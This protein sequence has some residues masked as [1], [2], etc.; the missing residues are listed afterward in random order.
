MGR[1]LIVAP[2]GQPAGWRNAKYVLDGMEKESCTSLTL[3]VEKF[4]VEN[5]D[6]AILALDSLVDEYDKQAESKCYTCYDGLRNV[7]RES[8][9]AKTYGELRQSSTSF[10]KKF[11][12]CLGLS[13]NPFVIICPAIGSPGGNWKFI[14]APSD[15]EALALYEIGRRCIETAYNRIVLDLSHGVNFMPA[16]TLKIA[17]GLISLILATHGEEAKELKNGVELQVY[18]SDPPPSTSS[19]SRLNINLITKS[20]VKTIIAPHQLSRR[21]LKHRGRDE[22]LMTEVEK[23]NSQYREAV[24]LSLSAVYYPLPLA[25]C[26]ASIQNNKDQQPK[27][28]LENAF[29]LWCQ[30]INVGNEVVERLLEIYPD[31]VYA[32][33]LTEAV[34]K[35]LAGLGNPP[36][37]EELGI[38]AKFYKVV[39][40]SFYYLIMDEKYRFESML[41]ALSFSGWVS[42]SQLYEEVKERVPNKRIM[43]AHAGL[44]KEFVEINPA[45]HQL[46]Y[47]ENARKIVE[48][49]SL[50]LSFHD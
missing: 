45:T 47:R 46:K 49:A 44:Q 48:D 3:L 18:N 12:E 21:L 19:V 35:R 23:L 8:A 50:L 26:E 32:L 17:S 37:L 13:C 9:A 28:I 38:L 7:I 16:V 34:G 6:V 20:R 5:V 24:L 30:H 36:K 39:N 1:T 31:A 41:R 43:I 40:E 33:L 22:T 27:Q 42:L 10:V 4:E 29:N 25:L 11:V 15:F 14:G 2:W